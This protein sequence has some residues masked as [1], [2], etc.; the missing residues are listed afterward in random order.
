[1]SYT[2]RGVLL[3]FGANEDLGE[4]HSFECLLRKIIYVV[5]GN[6]LTRVNIVVGSC[7]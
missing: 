3:D 7:V 5:L 1:M 6:L 4:N 2:G